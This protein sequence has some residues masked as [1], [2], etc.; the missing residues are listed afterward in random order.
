MVTFER[1]SPVLPVRNVSRALEYYRR[2]G[3][4]ARAYHEQQDG[5]PIY[6]YLRRGP[7]ELHLVRVTCLDPA[8]NT[9]A[10]YMYVSDADALYAEWQ[11]AG[12]ECR[13][14]APEDR[15]YG[16]REMA[17]TDPDGNLLRVGSALPQRRSPFER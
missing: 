14:M 7:I 9:S 2:L 12:V 3:F 1:A 5:D 16:L 6:G 8:A 10:V 4:D 17:L 15:A 11:A 13:L